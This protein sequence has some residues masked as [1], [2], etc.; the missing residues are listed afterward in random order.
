MRDFSMHGQSSF[1]ET[2]TGDMFKIE[3]FDGKNGDFH[4][5]AGQ[6]ER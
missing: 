4:A 1:G 5:K 6:I 3:H 2:E